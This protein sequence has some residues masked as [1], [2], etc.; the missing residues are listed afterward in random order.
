M[1]PQPR[2]DGSVTDAKVRI[3]EMSLEKTSVLKYRV[4]EIGWGQNA[5]EP[6]TIE[7]GRN[8]ETRRGRSRTPR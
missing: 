2:C 7:R 8:L 3:A 6:A 5:Q 1:W 4:R